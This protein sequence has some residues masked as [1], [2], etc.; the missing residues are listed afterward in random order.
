MNASR[1]ETV[2]ERAAQRWPLAREVFTALRSQA[3]GVGLYET[4]GTNSIEL[5]HRRSGAVLLRLRG[6]GYIEVP[7]DSMGR[8]RGLVGKLFQRSI[9]EDL[10][11]VGFA[12][13][14]DQAG[15][16]PQIPA[17]DVNSRERMDAL[18]AL[19]VRCADRAGRVKH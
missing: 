16:W 11:R 14:N 4:F 2:I 7:F 9:V 6:N 8:N 15:T 18:R 3:A 5:T 12:V 19:L 10:Q 17:S 13:R 1:G